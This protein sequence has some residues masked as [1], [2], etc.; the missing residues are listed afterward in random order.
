MT[1]RALLALP[2]LFALAACG[3]PPPPPATAAV[4]KTIIAGAQ[5]AS[6]VRTYSGEVRARHETTLAFRVGGKIV[7]RLVDVGAVVRP[8]QVLARID[9]ADLALQA[10]QAEAQR[11]LAEADARRY[12]DL[13]TKNFISQSALDA[14]ETALQTA[15]AQA[16][17]ARNQSAYAVLRADKAGAIAQVLAEPGQVVAAGQGVFRLAEAG[18]VEVAIAVPESG[19]AGLKPGLPAQ[20]GFWAERK[21][22]PARLRELSPV[23]DPAT[24]TYAVRVALTAADPA[25]ALGMTATVRFAQDGGDA[26][27][28]PQAAIFQQGQ[29]PA[30]WV[31]GADNAV[32]LRAVVL[33]SYDDAG[34]TVTA[35]LKPGER[36]VAAG[37]HKLHA[38]QK[39]RPL[40]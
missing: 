30:V 8:G 29:Q 32:T 4:V 15:G 35:G 21:P 7:E 18:A 6:V 36:I 3:E 37:V 27:V 23:A 26:L 11:A 39:V 14:K 9:P 24:R 13:R 12:R 19:L 31:V 5:P 40:Q 17:L 1:P 33:G 2:C 16:A 10:G 25:V 22:L 34:A 38:G 20:V 28:V